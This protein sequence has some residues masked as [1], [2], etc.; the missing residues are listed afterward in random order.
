MNINF[1]QYTQ[2]K[3]RVSK[4]LSDP[5]T[6]TGYLQEQTSLTNPVIKIALNTNITVC[7]YCYIEAFRRYYYITS[8]DVVD[9]ELIISLHC[10]VLMSFKNEILNS[11]AVI[12]RTAVGS[13]YIT[14][15]LVLQTPKINRQCQKIGVA[16]SKAEKYVIQIGG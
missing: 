5:I 7:N 11:K 6:V 13:N 3:N 14:D 8:I 12:N 16:F 1:Y 2:E 10:D 15:N 9:K 4:Q